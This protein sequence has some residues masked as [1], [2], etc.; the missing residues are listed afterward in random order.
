LG[1]AEAFDFMASDVTICNLALARISE[2]QILNIEEDSN[3]ARYCNAFY[4]QTRD[5]VLQSNPWR[6]ATTTAQ[7]SQLTGTPLLE[8]ENKFQ[9]PSDCLRVLS[10]NRQ[11]F[12]QSQGY[13][14]VQGTVLLTNE[15]EAIIK[16]IQRVT[17]GNLFTPLF[18]EALSVKLA[19]RIAKPLTGSDQIA[20]GLL[21]EY[22]RLTGPEARR[23]NAYVGRNHPA[24]PY[25]SSDLVSSRFGGRGAAWFPYW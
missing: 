21:E 24:L 8:W 9:L 15:A 2:D 11:W 19:A 25:V 22:V 23:L 4:A 10:L 13:F 7:L 14:E 16:Y 6:F 17:D 12:D 18:S 1:A 20:A 5:E 3:N